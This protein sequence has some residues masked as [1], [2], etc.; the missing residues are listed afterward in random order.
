MQKDVRGLAPETIAMLQQYEWPGN[1]REL[2]HSIERAVILSP[3]EIL[4]PQAFDG[5]RFGLSPRGSGPT[6]T[7]PASP[8]AAST[9]GA[10]QSVPAVAVVLTSLDVGDA[11]ARLITRALEVSGGNRTHAAGLLGISVRTLRNK[12]NG[13]AT[14][15]E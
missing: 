4:Q 6:P 3:N 10:A 2:Q 11:E 13:Q 14:S 7:R 15:G 1:V 12:L 9:D 5:Q 8:F